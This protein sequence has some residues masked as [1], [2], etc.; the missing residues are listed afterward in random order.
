MARADARR[1]LVG[2]RV[3]SDV[4]ER[5][6]FIQ[7]PQGLVDGLD[8]VFGRLSRIFQQLS[9]ESKAAEADKWV[10]T[11]LPVFGLT[12]GLC[13]FGTVIGCIV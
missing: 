10:R 12:I 7:Y 1:H 6:I 9:S 3:A 2:V 4:D 11:V 13:P 5:Q 8:D